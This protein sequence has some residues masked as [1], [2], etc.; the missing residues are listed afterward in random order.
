MP[1]NPTEEEALAAAKESVLSGQAA[2]V[3]EAARAHNVKEWTLR[4]RLQGIGPRSSRPVN[5]RKLSDEWEAGLLLHLLKMDDIGF[6]LPPEAIAAN[7]NFI[8]AQN[9]T[10]PASEPKKVGKKWAQGLLKRHKDMGFVLVHQESLDIRRFSVN[11]SKIIRIYF[12]KLR[13]ALE[14][15]NIHPADCYNMDETGFRI[16]AGGK[17]RVVTRNARGRAYAPSSTN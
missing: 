13:N 15:Y 7:A 8:L 5:N 12:Q 16:G 6:P 17:K 2:S 9:H 11:P 4:A 3:A 10:D 14:K 1:P